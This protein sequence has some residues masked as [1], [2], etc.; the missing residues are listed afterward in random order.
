MTCHHVEID[1]V[2]AIVCTRGAKKLQCCGCKRRNATRLCDA[3]VAGAKPGT[4]CSAPICTSCMRT[5][6]SRKGALD[7]CP[8][9]ARAAG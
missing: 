9:C 6:V 3:P 1:G 8:D 2:R 7:Y 5:K 4:T